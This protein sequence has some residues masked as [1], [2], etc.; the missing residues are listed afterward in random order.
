MTIKDK[1]IACYG[2]LTVKS[3]ALVLSIPISTIYQIIKYQPTKPTIRNHHRTYKGYTNNT[4][5]K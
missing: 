2:N 5:L 3:I 4:P 1:V